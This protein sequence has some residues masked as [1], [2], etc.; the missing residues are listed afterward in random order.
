MR[1]LV[2]LLSALVLVVAAAGS[3]VASTTSAK[4]SFVGEFD[5]VDPST[6]VLAGH[7]VAQ[8]TLPTDRQLSPGTFEFTGA[9][10]YAVRS[11]QVAVADSL[12]WIDPNGGLPHAMA[13]GAS[14]DISNP[15]E[16]TCHGDFAVMFREVPSEPNSILYT[17]C[18]TGP[19]IEDWD[20]NTENGCAV[21]LSVSKGDW[22]LKVA[23][24]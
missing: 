10:G 8:F 16:Y 5:V 23:P 1:R 20:F 15:H 4:N 17:T 9:P 2:A 12:F 24:E 22:V 7:V 6:G 14:C 11:M 3:S 21:L 13:V 19:T 18:R